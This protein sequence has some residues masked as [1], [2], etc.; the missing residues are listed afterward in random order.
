MKFEK[1]VKILAYYET[2][3]VYCDNIIEYHNAMKEIWRRVR[4]EPELREEHM[5]R[6]SF[7]QVKFLPEYQFH[8]GN[9]IIEGIIL[10]EKNK[11]QNIEL[12]VSDPTSD[13]LVHGYEFEIENWEEVKGYRKGDRINV[14]LSEPIS[15][16]S[17]LY[18]INKVLPAKKTDK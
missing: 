6:I 9:L 13:L 18:W 8:L 3:E 10:K 17:R 4:E 2:C 5:I 1:P 11:E 7:G 16:I 12:L 14:I 15:E